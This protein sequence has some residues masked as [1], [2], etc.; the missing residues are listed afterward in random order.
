MIIINYKQ[1]EASNLELAGGP[2]AAD[3]ESCLGWVEGTATLLGRR[4]RLLGTGPERWGSKTREENRRSP[5]RPGLKA[6]F[7]Y[8]VR[9][10]LTLHLRRL[11]YSSFDNCDSGGNVGRTKLTASSY[12]GVEFQSLAR[13]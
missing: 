5:G 11:L 8:A 4:P 10:D 2:G 12:C 7:G 1:R 3:R 6:Q 13:A 9:I